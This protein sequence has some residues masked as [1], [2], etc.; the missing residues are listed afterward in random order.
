MSK[1]PTLYCDDGTEVELPFKW[2]I[3]R[4]CDGHNRS[5]AH[6]ECDGGGFTSSEW[7]EQDDDFKEG[8]LRGDYDRPCPECEGGKVKIPDY[9]MMT[10]DQ[11]ELYREQCRSLLE[12]KAEEAM[13]RRM[14][15]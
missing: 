13:E 2:A 11:R 6:V 9:A 8:Y 10:K 12:L 14:G 7:A 15:A 4:Q 5:L 1:R 3:C